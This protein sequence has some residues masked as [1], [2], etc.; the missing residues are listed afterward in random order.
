PRKVAVVDLGG[1]TFDVSI[2]RVEDGVFEVLAT[3]GD[4]SLGGDDFDRRLGEAFSGAGRK[5][6]AIE[7]LGDAMALQGLKVD[8]EKSKHERA[9]TLVSAA[10]LPFLAQAQGQPVHL[11]QEVRR[12]ELET[13]TADLLSALEPSCRRALKDARLDPS[14]L[15]QVILVGGMTRMPAV[16]QRIEAIFGKKAS[17]RV[18]PDEIVAVGAATQ[19][20]VLQ[21]SLRQVVLLDVTPLALSISAQGHR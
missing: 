14:A 15:D 7:V 12:V 16:Q 13:L 20:A 17:K 11:Q 10:N 1:G 6:S 4:T 9:E 18:N 3:A 8:A 5:Q 19:S 21:G 2:L